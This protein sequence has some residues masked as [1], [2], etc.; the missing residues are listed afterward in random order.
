M[1][2]PP[3]PREAGERVGVRGWLS[4]TEYLKKDA[5]ANTARL[6]FHTGILDQHPLTPT[7][8]PTFV[9]ERFFKVQWACSNRLR[10]PIFGPTIA[11]RRDA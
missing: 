6:T 5:A 7:L 8:S 1:N 10:I 2:P 4:R 11:N 9:G 3:L